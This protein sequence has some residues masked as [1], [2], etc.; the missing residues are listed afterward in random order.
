MFSA[1]GYSLG[2]AL[3][4]TAAICTPI[5]AIMLLILRLPALR[6]SYTWKSPLLGMYWAAGT[7]SVL[8]FA[9]GMF[10]NYALSP[11]CGTDHVTEVASPDAKHKIVVYNFDCGA[12]TDFSLLVSLLGSKQQLPKNKAANS[13]YSHYHQLPEA[14]GIRKNF[15]VQWHDSSH[16]TVRIASY[17]GATPIKSQDGVVVSFENWPSP[18]PTAVSKSSKP[19][20]QTPK[21]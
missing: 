14:N 15:E 21:P 13:L 16:V 7:L 17:D 11:L 8:V 4:I 19:K 18:I 12:T 5:Y 3:A 9:G 1:V 6:A 2:T 20:A 10:L